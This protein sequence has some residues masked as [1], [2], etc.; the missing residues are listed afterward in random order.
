MDHATVVERI[1]QHIRKQGYFVTAGEPD[2]ETRLRHPRVA[3]LAVSGGYNAVRV[4]LDSPIAGQVVTAV[5]SAHPD[6][7]VKPTMGGS[8]PL[9]V[10]EKVLGAPVVIVP[11]ANHDNN[12]H[13]HNENIRIQNVW[14]GIET[15]AALLA[16]SLD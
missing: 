5:R 1:V 11:I 4:P 10:F 16:L 3:R 13:S 14:D 12:Q 6:A 9:H 2:R 7:I 15:M 8:L